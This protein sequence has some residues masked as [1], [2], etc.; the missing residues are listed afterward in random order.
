M[1]WDDSPNAGFTAP[2]ITPWLPIAGDYFERNIARQ[3]N[4]PTS[5]LS[6][7]RTLSALRQAEPALSVG[8]YA[9]VESGSEDAFA[10]LRSAPGAVHFLIVLNFSSR[11]QT[12][13]FSHVAQEAAITISTD[14]V[15]K[16]SVALSELTL[17]PDE[18]LVLQL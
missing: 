13:N 5:M 4:D 3:G 8:D 15:R 14:M 6:L 12:L 10:Y 9:S 16:G 11:P 1:Q 17:G 7:Y 18:G 2:G